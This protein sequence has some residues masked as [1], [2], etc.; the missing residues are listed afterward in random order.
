[1]KKD[2]P[3]VISFGESMIRFSTK[4]FERIEQAHELE[5]RVAGAESN[6]AIAFAR[7]GGRAAWISKIT[8]N[9]LGRFIAN[10]IREHG[11]DVSHVIWTND[12][13][14]GL[15][16]IEF[17][18]KPRPTQVIYDRK[19]SAIANI[20]PNEVDWEI[21]KDY[22]TFH[23]T[24]ITVALSENC[25]K[26]VEIGISKAKEFGTRVSFDVNYRSKLW[27]PEEAFKAL[28]PILKNVDILLVTKDDARNVLKVDGTYEEM[29][30]TLAERYNAEVT[31]LTLGSEGAMALKDDRIYK[32]EPYELEVVDRIGAGDAFD[33]GFVYEYLRSGD[34]QKALELGIAMA[35]YAHTI[36]GDIMF[37]T[38]DELELVITQKAHAHDVLR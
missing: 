3:S 37:V 19:N 29:I 24:G 21:L 38:K 13:R 8:N 28:D 30:H 12:Y 14:V 35:A 7:L 33:A 32:A 10:K 23:T 26:A 27:S 2:V 4:N 25:K 17:G 11:V 20:D 34:I 18:K 15:Y 9:P 22:D 5:M 1:M 16:F 31:V 6:F 36:P